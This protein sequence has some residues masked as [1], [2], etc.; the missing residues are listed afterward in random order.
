MLVLVLVQVCLWERERGGEWVGD[1]GCW[2]VIRSC[3]VSSSC[4]NREK[5][6]EKENLLLMYVG[7]W[8]RSTIVYTYM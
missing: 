8:R 3:R 4:K 7:V 2:C 1:V 6:L 5:I